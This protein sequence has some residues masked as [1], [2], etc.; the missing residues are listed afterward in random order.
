VELSI[1]RSALNG[2]SDVTLTP[3][4]SVMAYVQTRAGTTRDQILEPI[5]NIIRRGMRQT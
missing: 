1:D 2:V 3:G 5:T 4:M